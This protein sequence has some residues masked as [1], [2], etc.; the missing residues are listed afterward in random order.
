MYGCERLPASKRRNEIEAFLESVVGPS[1]PVLPYDEAAAAWH[2][3]ERAR[4][5]RDGR[6]VPFVDGQ[7][8]AI[9]VVG[10]LAIVTANPRDFVRFDGLKVEDWSKR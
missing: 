5:E 4:L 3:A 7:I 1:F 6:P 9:A 8:A 10:K 2:G